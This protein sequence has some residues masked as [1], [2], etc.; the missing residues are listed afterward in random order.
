MS[1][2]QGGPSSKEMGITSEELLTDE[3][4]EQKT[5]ESEQNSSDINMAEESLKEVV[6]DPEL[7]AEMAYAIKDLRDLSIQ[8]REKVKK[9]FEEIGLNFDSKEL[10]NLMESDGYQE[11]RNA[12]SEKHGYELASAQFRV[13]LKKYEDAVDIFTRAN[14]Y[15]G[16]ASHHENYIQ[17]CAN[18]VKDLENDNDPTLDGIKPEL[19]KIR[20][21]ALEKAVLI[22]YQ[23]GV[24][25]RGRESTVGR[26]KAKIKEGSE[27]GFLRTVEDIMGPLGDIAE[28]AGEKAIKSVRGV[29]KWKKR[30]N[31]E[32]GGSLQENRKKEEESAL[33]DAR[34]KLKNIKG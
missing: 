11:L 21:E 17:N 32:V 25:A 26:V 23:D 5:I 10:Q 9:E 15:E 24:L 19:I 22:S 12:F 27:K 6:E 29:I 20:K 31:E 2:E 33:E 4:K 1:R 18:R 3:Q 30:G 14:Q 16:I 34:E 13:V 7:A 28:A 8:L